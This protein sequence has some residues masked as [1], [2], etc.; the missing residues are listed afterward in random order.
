VARISGKHNDSD[1]LYRLGAAIRARRKS[2]G[3][4][5]EGLADAAGMERAYIGRVERGERNVT[6]LNVEKI[7]AAL[8]LT[9]GKLMTLADS[10]TPKS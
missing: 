8:D 1:L 7:S 3:L 2:T 4:S 9:P 6:I 10:I 5:Q